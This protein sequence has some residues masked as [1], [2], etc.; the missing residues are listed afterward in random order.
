M[1]DFNDD[2]DAYLDRLLQS[3][4][5]TLLQLFERKLQALKITPTNAYKIMGLQSR[6]M[7]GILT[8]SQK[9]IDAQNLIKLANFLQIPKEQVFE[10]YL[11][12]VA[13][14]Y[15]VS[16]VSAE[17]INFIKENF[18]LASLRKAKLIDNITDFE[19][20]KN[21]IKAR[22]GLK[23][24]FEYR[25]PN[26]DIAFSSGLFKPENDL[27]RA[28][29]INSAQ[30]ILSEIDNQHPY[31]KEGLIKIFPRLR[32][33]SMNVEKGLIE[34]ARLLYKIGITVIYQA[35]MQTLKL[36][37]AT[38]SHNGKPCI[39]LTNYRGF[40]ATLW[41]AL[42]HELYHVLFDWDEIKENKY[43]LTDDSNE[44]LSVQEREREADNFARRYLFSKEK[45]DAI[46]P[47]LNDDD[48]VAEFATDNHIEKSIIYVLYAFDYQDDNRKAW[49]RAKRYSPK[50]EDCK[51]PLDMKWED[52]RRVEVAVP[53]ISVE[54]Y[55][56]M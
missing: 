28:F 44:Q 26:V 18:D 56:K 34:V 35:P 49:A 42:F 22:L 47:F 32:W 55:P 16:N 11:D 23:S 40:Y 43:H 51:L 36:R 54:T 20:I 37:G 21:R 1:T 53:Q 39:V 17:E 5:P 38:F 4:R 46:L 29:W 15:P 6:T 10:L 45:M 50:I 7:N 3:A 25:K 52:D 27:I 24:I 8:G 19:H 13:V 2:I 9:L 33:Y 41:F 14:N 12:A 31:D 48:Y 30:A